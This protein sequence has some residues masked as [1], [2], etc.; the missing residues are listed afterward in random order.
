[1]DLQGQKLG[2]PRHNG[3]PQPDAL[4]VTVTAFA[5]LVKFVEDPGLVAIFNP[6]PL[7]NDG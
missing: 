5:D 2:K 6:R 3:E 4:D 1:M 7:I